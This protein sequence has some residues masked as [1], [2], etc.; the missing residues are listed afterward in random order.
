MEKD[1]MKYEIFGILAVFF[2]IGMAVG[3]VKEL[4]GIDFETA[5]SDPAMTK[6]GVSR[7]IGSVTWGTPTGWND[8]A[9]GTP[10][11]NRSPALVGSLAK[12]A[13][14]NSKPDNVPTAAAQVEDYLNKTLNRS[15]VTVVDNLNATSDDQQLNEF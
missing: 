12:E 8:A 10:Y 2:M 15:D 4:S 13:Y 3:E 7:D 9:D 14:M 1:C 5:F 6:D 11:G